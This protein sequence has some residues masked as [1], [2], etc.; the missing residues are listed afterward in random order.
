LEKGKKKWSHELRR[1]T[2]TTKTKVAKVRAE[3]K[4]V[5]AADL[6]QGSNASAR[7]RHCSRSNNLFNVLFKPRHAIWLNSHYLLNMKTFVPSSS[8]STASFF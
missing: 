7:L 2:T 8:K 4:T 6:T 5:G 3:P 1:A